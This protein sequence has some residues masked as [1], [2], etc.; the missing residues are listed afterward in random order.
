MSGHWR[1]ISVYTN[2][3]CSSWGENLVDKSLSFWLAEIRWSANMYSVFFLQCILLV[4]SVLWLCRIAM[5]H[6]YCIRMWINCISTA[7]F[8]L[9]C[10]VSLSTLQLC[11][12]LTSLLWQAVQE[13]ETYL[14]AFSFSFFF[15]SSP[16]L[17]TL[18]VAVLTIN[19][20]KH[21]ITPQGATELLT[22]HSLLYSQAM[23]GRRRKK[24]KK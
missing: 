22:A 24:K 17:K 1:S 9:F 4:L 15:C 20:D 18:T 13:W 19:H 3:F 21:T 12:D 6:E 5:P 16:E 2:A 10:L 11:Q 8:C 23:C 14:I 7:H